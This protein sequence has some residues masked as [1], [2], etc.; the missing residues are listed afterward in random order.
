MSNASNEI[1]HHYHHY[2]EKLLAVYFQNCTLQSLKVEISAVTKG[3]TNGILM[4]VVQLIKLNYLGIIG[5]EHSKKSLKQIGYYRICKNICRLKLKCL[6][7][8][9]ISF[10][11]NAHE[12][13]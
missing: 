6:F 10:S 9:L 11:L 1:Q 12:C 7:V 8:I 13:I 2:S 5:P 3:Y 4:L